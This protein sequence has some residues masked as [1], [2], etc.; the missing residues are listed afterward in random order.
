MGQYRLWLH[1]REIDHDLRAQHTKYE[2]ELAEIDEYV[3]RIENTVMQKENALLSVLIQHIHAQQQTASKIVDTTKVQS[4]QNGA[5]HDHQ[6]SQEYQTFPTTDYGQQTT[7]V[8][9]ALLAW[10]QLPNFDTHEIP[11]PTIEKTISSKNAIPVL[12]AATD[13]LLP[14]DLN[15]LFDQES[16][17][18]IQRSLPWWLRNIMRTSREEQ[19]Q[20]NLAP[21]DQ[22]SMHINQ[23]VERW[24]A[25]RNKIAHHH[26]WQEDQK[27]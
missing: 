8:S 4:E 24:F 11:I 23:R 15:T 25:R 6:Y 2:Q 12:P 18:D 20:Q 21:I 22:Q 26:E 3:T 17:K 27:K 9:P 7:S 1:H 13:H 19:K 16:P 14:S 10:S 5:T